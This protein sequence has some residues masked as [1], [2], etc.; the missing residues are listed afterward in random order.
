MRDDR[1]FPGG[2]VVKT[3]HFHCRG[4]KARVQSLVADPTCHAVRPKKRMRDDII[5][6]PTGPDEERLVS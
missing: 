1:D 4:H 2:P 3:L 6:P 5:S